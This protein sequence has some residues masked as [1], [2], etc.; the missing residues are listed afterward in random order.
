MTPARWRLISEEL[1]VLM[2]ISRD[3][4]DARLDSIAQNDA[5]LRADLFRYYRSLHEANQCAY[6]ER[7]IADCRPP[8]YSLPLPGEKLG[9]YQLL[10]LIGMGGMGVVYEAEQDNPLRSVALKIVNPNTPDLSIAVIRQFDAEKEI[11]SRLKHSSIA[12]L[13]DAGVFEREGQTLPFFAMELVEGQHITD[14][15]RCHIQTI[16]GRIELLAT[17]CEAVQ[18]AH[19]RGVIHCDLKPS[20]IL[21]Q[22]GGQPKVL[23]FGIG[24]ASKIAQR[25]PAFASNF[26]ICGGTLPYMSP[27]QLSLNEQEIDHQ[28]DVHALGVIAYELLSE[29]H[30]FA[31]FFGMNVKLQEHILKEE[32]PHLKG[33]GIEFHRDLECIIAKA[34]A[35]RKCNRYE[36]ALSFAEDMRRYLRHE[37][38][39]AAKPWSRSYRPRCFYRRNRLLC[40]ISLCLLLTIIVGLIGTGWQTLRAQ[41]NGL[42]AEER[43][44]LA[45]F[46]EKMERQN[47]YNASVKLAEEAWSTHDF[48]RVKALLDAQC[49]EPGQS[50]LRGFEWYYLKR[51]SSSDTITFRNFSKI[52]AVSRDG[53]I[54]ALKS[55]TGKA[56]GI[57]VVLYD[58]L[59]RREIARLTRNSVGHVTAMAFS[60]DGRLLATGN[61]E[62]VI[63]FLNPRSLEKVRTLS[64]HVGRVTCLSFS[65]DS[66]ELASG[67]A[68]GEL[69]IWDT[70]SGIL[71]SSC[72]GDARGIVSIAFSPDGGC[73]ASS[74]REGGIRL[75]DFVSCEVKRTLQVSDVVF[76]SD[77]VVNCLLFSCDGPFLFGGCQDGEIRIWDLSK[78]EL[79]A[80]LS[81]HNASV[82]DLALS[83]NGR[84]LASGS[85]DRTVRVWDMKSQIC[86]AILRGHIG[87]VSSVRFGVSEQEVISAGDQEG[88]VKLWNWRCAQAFL[89]LSHVDP[90]NC[91]ALSPDGRI[92]AA[93]TSGIVGH[94]ET[95][96]RNYPKLRAVNPRPTPFSKTKLQLAAE[97]QI[98]INLDEVSS[99]QGSAGNG[100]GHSL[101]IGGSGQSDSVAGNLATGQ[102]STS[103]NTSTSSNLEGIITLWDAI[104]GDRIWSLRR[105]RFNSSSTSGGH[106]EPV[107][108]VVF[109][110]D[111]Q[112]LASGDRSGI[113]KIWATRSWSLIRTFRMD[114]LL[115][116]LAFIDNSG[117]LIAVGKTAQGNVGVLQVWDVKTGQTNA[118]L[119]AHSG[120]I[121]C[122]A[123]CP[124][125][126]LM[127]TGGSDRN[128]SI[129]RLPSLDS[130]MTLQCR[131]RVCSL[132]FSPDGALLASATKSVEPTKEPNAIVTIWGV[133]SGKEQII[134]RGLT[135][136]VWSMAF[137]PDGKT[138]ATS[139]EDYD[140]RLWDPL[141]GLEKLTLK[142][143]Q[144]AVHSV[145][146]MPDSRG[147]ITAGGDGVVCIW[148][149]AHDSEQVAK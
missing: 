148:R 26:M 105:D 104:T 134:I 99:S 17:V 87:T 122:I 131:T 112:F 50:D 97:R 48:A 63:H 43:Q 15:S 22:S 91:F 139:S 143:H 141:T 133:K 23:D 34:L 74:D 3:R 103:P 113:V 6:L 33:R 40:A 83:T 25:E 125:R 11:H 4:V 106:S 5:G 38:V 18:Y 107:V 68:D 123:V 118:I 66:L 10:R 75:W 79:T 29:R 101:E 13:Y 136:A 93:A 53:S 110:D 65:S 81:G 116:A 1:S 58:A 144:K 76:N 45:D 111:G 96:A 147:L 117:A 70:N 85:L 146:F 27:E 126:T 124:D 77:N 20:N 54:W 56:T 60:N 9:R 31:E 32:R 30:P 108:S 120:A 37:P 52:L 78:F 95:D 149:G 19:L 7:P 128:V 47:A 2:G 90:V 42:L 35:C 44:K 114:G 84:W 46:R 64:G 72:F 49:P 115:K 39:Y 73:L 62:G 137:S 127:A 132:S 67:S 102:A 92:V 28:S 109:S 140:V 61:R 88:V 8:A 59:S 36:S 138:L 100:K 57:D 94:L 51:V 16:Q 130:V 86:L 82:T 12:H 119:P 80:M 24:R 89:N 14:Y 135:A 71:L 41:H 142:N 69:G 21:V 55:R 98:N 121:T 129:W 145:G